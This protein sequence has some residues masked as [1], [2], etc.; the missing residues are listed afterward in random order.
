MGSMGD[1]K[2]RP[3]RGRNLEDKAVEGRGPP[4]S[5]GARPSNPKHPSR[6]SIHSSPP[7]LFDPTTLP[8]FLQYP[9]DAHR[10]FGFPGP[11][12]FPIP[13]ANDMSRIRRPS[14]MTMIAG[15]LFLVLAHTPHAAAQS[16]ACE[17]LDRPCVALVLAG[18][19]ARGGVHVGVIKVLE[20]MQVPVDLVL[21]TSMGAVVGGVYSVGYDAAGLESVMAAIDWSSMFAARPPRRDRSM[22]RKE[23]DPVLTLDLELGVKGFSPRLPRGLLPDQNLNFLLQMLTSPVT[24]IN[25]FD[26]LPTPFRAVAADVVTGEAVI[27]EEGS[28]ANAI[29]ASLSLPGIFAPVALND[30]LLVDGG[31][32]MN[33]PVELA[34]EAGADV[35]IAVEMPRPLKEKEEFETA[36]AVTARMNKL[37][38]ERPQNRSREKL[39]DQ[40]VLMWP[41]LHGIETLD[42]DQIMETVQYGEEEARRF[43]NQ[44]ARYALSEAAWERFRA[45]RVNPSTE[46]PTVDFIRVSGSTAL[47]EEVIL[48]RLGL[49]PGE[50]LDVELLQRDLGRIYGLGWFERVGYRF[51][52]ESSQVGL[53]ILLEDKPW[54]PGY[55]RSGLRMYDNLSGQSGYQ[56][57][58]SYLAGP[59]NGRGGEIRLT[60]TLGDSLSIEGDLYQPLDN[61]GRFFGAFEA[62]FHRF[63]TLPQ[64]DVNEGTF[65][66]RGRWRR[67]A[68]SLGFNIGSSAEVRVTPQYVGVDGKTQ[69]GDTANVKLDDDEVSLETRILVDRLDHPFFPSHGTQLEVSWIAATDW[70]VG[71]Q[72]FHLASVR[73]SVGGSR[74]PNALRLGLEAGTS[75]GTAVPLY[76]HFRLGGIGRLSGLGTSAISGRYLGL[77]YLRYDRTLRDWPDYGFLRQL[78][79]GA[80]AE[81]GNIW[82]EGGQIDAGDLLFGASAFIGVDTLVGPFL[83]GFGVGSDWDTAWY[84]SLGGV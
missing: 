56:L 59:V 65:L 51:V 31:I 74:G 35:I 17:G 55:L 32:A 79:V 58:L 10:A 24:G 73:G 76:R 53:E 20:E 14:R 68:G 66:A 63:T 4:D 75:F 16:K 39:R 33:F 26:E 37:L 18:G 2:G 1:G 15:A 54:G 48:S 5:V 23:E 44:L 43:E 82:A 38:T 27:L 49:R 12:P 3:A 60:G 19:G 69:V 50:P 83:V 84:L 40:D 78:R 80:T 7:P 21:G 36:L 8:H 72:S 81:T 64:V 52:R 30:L 46:L 25:T 9:G 70:A 11:Y 29:R 62:S 28:L 71:D 6:P 47:N 42:F 61:A 57:T 77:A 41:D 13:T 22:R 34:L 45:G 67:L